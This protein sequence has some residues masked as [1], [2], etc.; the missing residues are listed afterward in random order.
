MDP[1]L[2]RRGRLLAGLLLA[3]QGLLVV[4]RVL[5]HEAPILVGWA[6]LALGLL[7]AAWGRIPPLSST[8]SAPS[9]SAAAASRGRALAVAG[10]GAFA[11]AG[12]VGYNALRGSTMGVPELAIVAYGVALLAASRALHRRVLGTDVNTLVAFS[13][14]L[15]L[16]PLS[17]YAV[18]AALASRMAQ[19]PLGW[20]VENT[21]VVPM[22]AGLQVFGFDAT[23]IGD[24]VRMATPRGVLFLS[25]GVVCAGIYAS[26]LFL[27][28]FGLFAWERRTPPMRLAAYL[29]VGLLGL[30][31]ANVLRLVLLGMVGYKWGGDALQD[32]HQHA[33]WVLFL[34]W[35]LGFWAVVLR[36]MEG[37][38]PPGVA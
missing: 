18:N 17:L 16:A 20:Y 34:V 8:S 37:P 27:G 38:A 21:L 22:A 14:P 35:S 36:R 15:V 24:T 11:V 25:V 12:V 7:L 13:F 30:H 32:F 19:T 29:A 6:A 4:T 5:D 10:L 3:G 28:V 33:G 26:V 9:P 23:M 1:T 31:V 2:L